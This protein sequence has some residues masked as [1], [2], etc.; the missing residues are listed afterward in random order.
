VVLKHW[1]AYELARE[2]Y[3]EARFVENISGPQSAFDIIRLLS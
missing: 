3:H 2:T 1:R